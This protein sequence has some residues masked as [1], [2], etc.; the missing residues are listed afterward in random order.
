LE[1]SLPI[2]ISENNVAVVVVRSHLLQSFLS[3]FLSFFWQVHKF[4]AAAFTSPQHIL[5][6]FFAGPKPNQLVYFDFSSYDCIV[7]G[8][9]SITGFA[10]RAFPTVVPMTLQKCFSHPS[11]IIYLFASQPIKLKGELHI[12]GNN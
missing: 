6:K 1:Q 4:F 3:F 7:Q 9:M 5:C 12:C 8:H 11:L 10:L 2:G